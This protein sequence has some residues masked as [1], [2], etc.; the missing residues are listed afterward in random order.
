MKLENLGPF[1]FFFTLSCADKRWTEN[2][3]SVFA[4]QNKKITYRI[5]NGTEMIYVDGDPLIEILENENLHEILRE[6]I[7]VVARNFNQRVRAFVKNI[8]MGANNPI[9]TEYYNYRIEFQARGAGHVHGVIWPRFDELEAD[10]PGISLALETLRKSQQLSEKQNH[11]VTEL[12][13]KFISCSLDN[14][15]RTTLEQVQIHNHSK[16]CRKYGTKCRFNFPRLPSTRTI[17]AQPLRLEDF[18]SE[19]VL[20]K[21][22]SRCKEILKSVK[23]QLCQLD[24][25]DKLEQTTLDE[26]L[27][28]SRVSSD[29]YHKALAVSENGTSIVLR[30]SV[31]DVFVNNYNPEW[32][33]AW[34]ANMDLQVCLDYYAVL[35]YITDYY[36]KDDSGT[37]QFLLDATKEFTGNNITEKMKY[38]AN[39]FLTHR[40][41]GKFEAFYS[42]DPSLHLTDSNIKAIYVDTNMPDKRRKFLVKVSDDESKD[43]SP[44]DDNRADQDDDCNSNCGSEID[45]DYIPTKKRMVTIPGKAGQY[46]ERSL[47]LHTRYERRPLILKNI[48]FVQ[49]CTMYE[50]CPRKSAKNLENGNY[51]S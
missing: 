6:N 1:L 15:L 5:E 12:V 17:I 2:F 51:V 29:E 26:L 43:A 27:A 28:M 35:T 18:E 45:D 24:D 25:E 40:Q 41:K 32:I 3:T 10:F 21:E 20:D 16:T 33:R 22:K 46:V 34:N 13:D 7:D 38:L 14:D 30:R 39:V 49:F 4:Q 11:V 23:D 44:S 47:S 9:R 8:M 42:I 31:A 48:S 37:M 19:T 50:T 36:M